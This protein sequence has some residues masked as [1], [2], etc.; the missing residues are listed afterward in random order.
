MPTMHRPIND[1]K[2]QSLC[3]HH[4]ISWYRPT[5]RG[6]QSI[7]V[8]VQL[9]CTLAY[10]GGLQA[11]RN[12]IQDGI[13]PPG[14]PTLI[15]CVFTMDQNMEQR[16]LYYVPTELAI[17]QS[18]LPPPF[19]DREGGQRVYA[20]IYSKFQDTTRKVMLSFSACSRVKTK[21]FPCIVY[22]GM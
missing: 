4:D 15:Q 19:E 22:S 2:V 17:D 10:K 16:L 11:T 5:T 12:V 20:A 7:Q 14:Q 21:R 18:M 9:N 8:T 6:L 3:L 1:D 13:V